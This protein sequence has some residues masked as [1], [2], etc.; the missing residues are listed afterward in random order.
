MPMATRLYAKEEQREENAPARIVHIA[1]E[2]VSGFDTLCGYVDRTDY[3]WVHING[4]GP[5]P[6]CKSCLRIWHYVK[7]NSI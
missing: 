7:V 3:K 2:V 5:Q 4:R 1:G 6:N